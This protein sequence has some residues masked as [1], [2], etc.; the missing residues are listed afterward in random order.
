MRDGFVTVAVGTP[1]VRVADCVPI[2][3]SGTKGDGSPVI[4]A[5]HAGWRGTVSKI[6]AVT[7]G[8]MI[9]LGCVP[10]SVRAAIGTHI[11]VC[12]Y[13]VGEDF[14]ASVSSAVSE[15]FAARHIKSTKVAGKYMADL[16]GMNLEIL[17][18]S[19]IS[20]EQVDISPYCTACDGDTFFSHRKSSGHRGTMGAG[21]VILP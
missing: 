16:T 4:G 7:V 13:E 5:A 3:F 1:S 15:E 8:K 2:L 10:E 18:A 9:A 17:S 11:G 14:Y 19:G 21:I 6:A 12:C 20:A